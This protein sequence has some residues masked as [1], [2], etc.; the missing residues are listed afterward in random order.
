MGW[1]IGR[2]RE[3]KK[4]F[5]PSSKSICSICENNNVCCSHVEEYSSKHEFLNRICRCLW[6]FLSPPLTISWIAGTLKSLVNAFSPVQRQ[7]N[8]I[9]IIMIKNNNK[10]GCKGISQKRRVEKIGFKN[11]LLPGE[12]IPANHCR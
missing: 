6:Y 10:N 5:S 7:Y 3:N 11:D 8:I 4:L 9:K 2:R 1:K 12:S